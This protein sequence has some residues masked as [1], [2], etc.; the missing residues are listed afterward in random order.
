MRKVPLN[1]SLASPAKRSRPSA[2]VI[3]PSRLP[4][5]PRLPGWGVLAVNPADQRWLISI[6]QEQGLRR[7]HLFHAGCHA[8]DHLFLAG[9]AVGAP[10]AGILLEKLIALGAHSILLFGWCGSLVPA[11][12]PG[13]LLVPTTAYS[14]EG[15]SAHY[16]HPD[17]LRGDAYLE[18][19]LLSFL[20]KRQE[21][22]SRGQLWSTDAP[23]RET[24]EKI[25]RLAA[26]GIVGVDMEYAAL[27]A[28]ARWRE[29]RLSGLMLVSDALSARQWQPQYGAKTFRRRSGQIL[30]ML[31]DLARQQNVL[32]REAPCR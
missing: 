31:A 3:E 27:C 18:D 30:A 15:T 10:M 25:S 7:Y 14:E 22:F 19:L 4:G 9:P 17:P 1:D 32:E 5:E 12:A 2:C 28:I 6:G 26:Q 8:A 11:L 16:P 13:S 29:V 23:Y 24:R 20:Q 21:P